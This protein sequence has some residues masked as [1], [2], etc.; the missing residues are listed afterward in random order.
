MTTKKNSGILRYS[1]GTSPQRDQGDPTLFEV[2]NAE[3]V[4]QVMGAGADVLTPDQDDQLFGPSPGHDIIPAFGI[5]AQL[6]AQDGDALSAS[7]PHEYGYVP[8]GTKIH[9]YFIQTDIL[10]VGLVAVRT[11]VVESQIRKDGAVVDPLGPSYIAAIR[12][13]VQAFGGDGAEAV[14][15]LLVVEMQHSEHDIPGID[16][17][18]QDVLLTPQ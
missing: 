7:R 9:A 1:F 2:G 5:G 6:P 13:S 4:I 3:Q 14:A 10:N 12:I 18:D 8:S 15:G 11:Q 16:E 17:Q